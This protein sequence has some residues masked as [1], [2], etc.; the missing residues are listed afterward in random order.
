M[1]G[2]WKE[3]NEVG[4]RSIRKARTS[5][6]STGMTIAEIPH[7]GRKNLSRPYP[8]VRHTP[9]PPWRDGN[10]SFL[11]EMQGQR[12]EQGLKERPSRDCPTWGSIPHTDTKHT[13][14]KKC[15]LTGT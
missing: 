7:E 4:K 13:H 15:L 2:T 8:E 5:Q 1:G 3:E 6:G 11:K 12:V 14:S 10:C 9:P